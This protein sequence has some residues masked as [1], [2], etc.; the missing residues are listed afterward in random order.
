MG[1]MRRSTNSLKYARSALLAAAVALFLAPSIIGADEL[2]AARVAP[3]VNRDQRVVPA[4]DVESPPLS[5]QD[6]F[7]FGELGPPPGTPGSMPVSDA[8]Q[9]ALDAAIRDSEESPLAETDSQGPT[10][11]ERTALEADLR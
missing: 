4:V 7:E 9:A 2:V 1:Y 3:P 10:G 6:V 5:L 11:A 8:A